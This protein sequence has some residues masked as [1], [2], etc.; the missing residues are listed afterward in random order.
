MQR[1]PV[2][3]RAT[4]ES[5]FIQSASIALGTMG[6]DGR[7]TPPDGPVD[8]E[9]LRSTL[10]EY[11]L[12]VAI[13]FGSHVDGTAHTQ[14]DIDVGVLF[15]DDCPEAKRREF[16]LDLHSTLAMAVGTDNVDVTLLDDVPASVGR[17][18]LQSYEVLV[19]DPTVVADLREHYEETAPSRDEVLARLD[20]KLV[21]L[22]EQ[23]NS[24]EA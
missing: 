24:E 18:A 6:S 20:E 10:E 4:A 21:R 22:D 3:M 11:P 2:R 19:G 1:D 9:A 14:S 16:Y 15:E 13:L 17:R 12:Q 5:G 7:S 8:R 23:A